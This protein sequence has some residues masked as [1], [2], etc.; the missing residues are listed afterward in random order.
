MMGPGDDLP[1]LTRRKDHLGVLRYIRLH[2]LREPQMV[3]DHGQSLL[4][5]DVSRRAGDELTRLAAIEQ[6]CLAALDLGN[7]ELAN[8]CLDQ[9][10]KSG[11]EKESVRFRRLLAR[12]L[13]ASGDYDGA[14]KIYDDFLKDNSANLVALQRKYCIAKAQDLAPEKIVEA[15]NEY[16][17]QNMADASGWYE[18]YELRMKYSDFK[19]AAYALEQVV[20]GCP[21][22]SEIH[23]ELAEVYATLGGLE[24]LMLARK[25][26]AQS[27]ELDG[28]NTKAQ[29]GLV[30]VAH[31]Y[32]KESA[33]A[34]K[35]NVDEHECLVAKELVKYGASQ[36]LKSHKGK[37]NYDAVKRSMDEY[38]SSLDKL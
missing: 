10:R 34:G 2:E 27:L 26:M 14:N 22:D 23:R 6:I 20:L 32:L 24:N 28:S 36:V 30:S 5:T 3:V 12:C 15:L 25:H 18:M 7:H 29:L 31:Q 35:K 9:L 19:G 1:S 8:T 4:G 17:G 37:D 38:T 13:E 33:S 16:L 21:L 11:V